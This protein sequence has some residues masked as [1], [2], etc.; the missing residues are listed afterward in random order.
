MKRFAV[1]YL[2]V[3]LVCVV[4]VTAQ[5]EEYA[6]VSKIPEGAVGER[7]RSVI[8]VVNSGDPERIRAFI[9][10]E[11]TDEF[12]SMVPMEEH[13]DVFLEVFGN[14][15]G[16]DFHSVRTYTPERAGQTVVILKDRK[17]GF[18]RSIVLSF[19][20]GGK[21]LIAG[22]RFGDARR[23]SNLPVEAPLSE[24]GFKDELREFVEMLNGKDI[25]SGTV[26]VA[27]GDD[28]IFTYVCGEASKRFHV[29]NTIETRF[30]LGSMNKMFTST[31]IAQLVEQGKLSYDD[32][33]SAYVDETWLPLEMTKKIKIRH[34][35]SHTSGLG[36][37]F[38]DAYVKGSRALFRDVDDF[39]ALVQGETLAFEPGSEFQYS[40][41]GMLILGVVIESVTGG[42]YFDYIR[43]N[44]YAPAGMTRSDS[45][46]MDLP[47]ENLAIGYTPDSDTK[48]GYRNNL[49]MHVIKGGPA[50]GGFSTVGD[51]HRFALAIE[52][53][54]LVSKATL[55]TM[56]T[57]QSEVG[58]GFGF[59]INNGSLGKV[60][61]HSGGFSGI[62]AKLD[63]Y[64]D[65]GTLSP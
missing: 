43:E 4:S 15:S 61:G 3:C 45:Y 41:T 33:I 32:A 38:N 47:V 36:S 2:L 39:K 62:S 50:G 11:C 6:D 26:L 51:L 54:K 48:F 58:Y 40:N 64:L 27:R 37:Y 16:I 65:A 59:G 34:L 1:L 53:G 7:I 30:N 28:V 44:I 35:L 56:W 46:E 8:D 19:D 29:P 21:N 49:Y 20:E 9:E 42:S 18:W 23:P 12:K 24:A 57:P 60:V 25:F 5:A 13:V 14:T 52:S 17:I 31:A 55:D 63:M 10:N 22:I